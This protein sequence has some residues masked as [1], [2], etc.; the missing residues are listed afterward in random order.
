[1]YK[2]K[3]VTSFAAAH[4][5]NNYQ[6][7]C[8]NLH[9]HNWRV[10]VTVTAKE[11]DKAGLCIDFKILKAQTKELLAT[12]DHKYLNEL[13]CFKGESPSSENISRYVFQELSRTFNDGN[14]KVDMIT[15]WESD[16]ACASYYEE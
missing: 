9:G 5:L 14:V 13:D 15:V 7:E 2:L 12:L 10:E 8:E 16:F 1:M 6:G 3:V 4:N 11:L